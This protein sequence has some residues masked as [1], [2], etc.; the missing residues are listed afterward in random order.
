MIRE[1]IK[2]TSGDLH[3]KLPDEYI[4]KEIEF[5]LFPLESIE[6]IHNTTKPK[7]SL[8]GVFSHYVDSS[9]QA[10]EESAWQEHIITKYSH[11]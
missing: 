4:N 7:K 9:K 1:V 3:I 2:P 10:L 5:I 11:E 6:K 8:R